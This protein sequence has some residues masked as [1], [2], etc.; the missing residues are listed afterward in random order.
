[1]RNAKTRLAWIRLYEET[2]DAGGCA[3][4]AAQVFENGGA[5]IK[6]LGQAGLVEQSRAPGGPPRAKYVRIQNLSSL[7]WR[8]A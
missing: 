6:R 3:V 5:A 4:D 7:S 2:G 1:V 8:L